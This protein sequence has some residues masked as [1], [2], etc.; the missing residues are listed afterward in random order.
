MGTIVCMHCDKV[1]EYFKYHK[2]TVLFSE[3]CKCN[4][5]GK[6]RK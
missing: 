2:V 3:H 1:I 5:K 6:T 4:K